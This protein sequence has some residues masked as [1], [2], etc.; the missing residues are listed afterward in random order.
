M[1]HGWGLSAKLIGYIAAGAIIT[2]VAVGIARV[3]NERERL[4]NLANYSGQNMANTTAAGAASLVVGYDYGNL[5]ILARNVADQANVMGVTILNRDGRIMSQTVA[6]SGRQYRRYKAPIVFDGEVIG[7]V[8]LDIS[9]ERLEQ[10]IDELYVRIVIEQTIIGLILAIIVYLFVSRG[11]VSPILRLTSAM[12]ATINK[13]EP[14]IAKQLDVTSGDEIGRLIKVFNKLNQQ[15]AS[16]YEKLQSKI[17]LADQALRNKNI[18]L[19]ARTDELENAL[20]MLSS[21]A[22]TDWLTKLPNRRQFDEV[23]EQMLSQAE[24]FK[25]PLS[26]ALIDVDNFKEINDSHGHAAGDEVLRQLGTFLKDAVRRSDAPARLGGDEFAVLL[27]HTAEKQAETLVSQ[28]LKKIKAHAF[29]FNGTKITVTLSA[30]IAELSSRN[31]SKQSLYFAADKALYTAK[32]RGR[33][34]YVLYSQL[35]NE[36]A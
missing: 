24:R 12:E 30:G 27:Y 3:K 9:T 28:L 35:P 6:G 32:H 29:S 14:Y 4:G 2:S 13:G 26:L 19:I 36:E 21:M 20:E 25:E 34:Q 16:N 17:D 18:E 5:E 33:D 8:A 22:T 10:A 15:L 1:A 11:I 31:N 7:S 23:F